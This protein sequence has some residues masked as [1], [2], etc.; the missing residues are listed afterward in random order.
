MYE[1]IK[2][3]LEA[4][5]VDSFE[6]SAPTWYLSEKIFKHLDYPKSRLDVKLRIG[7]CDHVTLVAAGRYV[8]CEVADS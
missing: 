6:C 3:S 5:T 1:T 2:K 4:M 7:S 8:T